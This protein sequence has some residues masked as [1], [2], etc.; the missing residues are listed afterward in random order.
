MSCLNFKGGDINC[1]R[2][3]NHPYLTFRNLLFIL[4]DFISKEEN[5]PFKF[6]WMHRDKKITIVYIFHLH[7]LNDAL[8]N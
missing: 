8:G 4:F 7:N 5:F 2:G 1:K 6:S 3:E